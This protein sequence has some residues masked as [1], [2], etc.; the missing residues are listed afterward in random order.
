[1]PFIDN[2]NIVL[3]ARKKKDLFNLLNSDKSYKEIITEI[4]RLQ[5]KKNWN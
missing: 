1:M 5:K 4:Y 2:Q 3:R